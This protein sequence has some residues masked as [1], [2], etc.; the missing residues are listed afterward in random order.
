MP[1][2][3]LHDLARLASTCKLMEEAF[4]DRSRADEKWLADAGVAVFGDR[5]IQTLIDFLTADRKEFSGASGSKNFDLSEGGPWPDKAELLSANSVKLRTPASGLYEGSQ[6]SL[7]TWGLHL[8]PFLESSVSL[9]VDGSPRSLLELNGNFAASLQPHAPGQ[10]VPLLGV[11]LL[12]CKGVAERRVALPH[13]R[14]LRK[15]TLRFTLAG[16]PEDAVIFQDTTWSK[17][18]A[19]P[20]D[21]LRA[22]SA[23]RVCIHRCSNKCLDFVLHWYAGLGTGGRGMRKREHGAGPGGGG[24]QGRG[25]EGG[26]R[27]R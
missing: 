26:E 7:V 6:P 16:K 25:K 5:V 13:W 20:P 24:E 9:M 17:P 11:I 18:G 23:L 12:A 3:S 8:D 19:G 21:A 14:P 10:S 1:A 27:N 2:V 4:H 22:L 15:P